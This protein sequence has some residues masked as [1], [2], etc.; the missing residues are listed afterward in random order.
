[1]ETLIYCDDFL[2]LTGA[3]Y[4]TYG[5]YRVSET[6]I[7]ASLDAASLEEIPDGGEEAEI[8][9]RFIREVPISFP[10]TPAALVAWVDCSDGDF[11]LPD[12]FVAQ[13][14]EATDGE[15]QVPKLERRDATR[16][17]KARSELGRIGAAAKLK[18]D[19]KQL[20]KAEVESFWME[21]KA[22]KHPKLK[23]TER[24]A[25]EAI[26]R[27]PV[28]TSSKVICDWSATWNKAAK[29]LRLKKTQST[30]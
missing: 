10:M 14:L 5:M 8:L 24:F 22:G 19:P 3:N 6:G 11:Q 2:R 12:E 25:T 26:R 7:E 29:E 21:W 20:A 4:G 17:A 15:Q 1:M 28:L 23:T 13:V 27:F 30:G 16:L 18:N 9:L